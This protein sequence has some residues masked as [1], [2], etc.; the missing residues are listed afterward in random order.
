MN[1]FTNY[2]TFFERSIRSNWSLEALTDLGGRSLTFAQVA[3]QVEKLHILLEKAGIAKGDRITLYAHNSANWGAAFVASTTYEAITVPL[4]NDFLTEDA[5]KL[6]NHSG[7]IVLFTEKDKWDKMDRTL[8]PSVRL[9]LCMD[10]FS[11]LFNDCGQQVVEA[12]DSIDALFERRFPD[13]G[14][15]S[16]SYPSDN[17]DKVA[18]INYTSG[19]SSSPK[20][21]MLTYANLS[22]NMQF[23]IDTVNGNVGENLVSMLPLAHMYGLIWEFMFQFASG[24][25]VYFLGKI[26][27]PRVLLDAFAKVRP[28]MVITVPLVI[29]KI[30]KN[31]VFPTI[32]KQPVKF[33]LKTPCLAPIIRRRI[34]SKLLDAFGGNL[35]Y[36]FIGGAAI[37]RD[38]ELWM[39]KLELPYSVGYGMTE[40]GPLIGYSDWDTYV[41]SSCGRIVHR[42]QIR[43]APDG[44]DAS[45][46][47]LQVK[48]DNV[49]KGYYDNEEA[50]KTAFTEDG[51]MRTGDLGTIDEGGNIYIKG[52]SKNMILSA[53]G[54]NIYPEELEDKLNNQPYVVESVVVE[55]DKKIV[56]L[57]FPDYDR[58]SQESLD[59]ND[60]SRLLEENRIKMN[61]AL[62]NYSKI[63]KIEIMKKPF[64]KTPKHSIKRF[65]Y[66]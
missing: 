39:K 15:E 18:L 28:Y 9:V 11:I 3:G 23:G 10:D 31:S 24:C 1:R 66:K 54:Q 20:G 26:P 37:N 53:N 58:V 63:A 32:E 14:P 6:I 36:M 34:R 46:G 17:M 48:G 21:V 61:L 38:V 2:L 52:R 42:M 35:R 25:H 43:V 4:L 49:M 29:E 5:Q 16:V 13:F 19:T 65:L 51:W 64:E 40:C 57:V 27:S 50:S 56:A 8:I 41:M 59:A 45:V 22:S 60:L 47:E 44:A 62:P 12:A 55:R 33:M 30:F 7:S